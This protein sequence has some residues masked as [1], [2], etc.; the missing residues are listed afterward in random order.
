METLLKKN[1]EILRG[2]FGISL[3]RAHGRSDA[4]LWNR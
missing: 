1:S 2:F 3:T 4:S